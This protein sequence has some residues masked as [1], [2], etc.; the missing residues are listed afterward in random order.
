MTAWG[1]TPTSPQLQN[2]CGHRPDTV[3]ALTERDEDAGG[4][5]RMKCASQ[6]GDRLASTQILLN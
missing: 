4:E 1:P 3:Q 5:Q 2:R 6:G